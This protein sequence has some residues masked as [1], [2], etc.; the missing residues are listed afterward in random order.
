MAPR[1][2]QASVGDVWEL[3]ARQ[4]WVVSRAQLVEL[5]LSDEMIKH[6]IRTRRLH[7]LWRRVYAVGHPQPTQL[8]LWM[9]AVLACGRGTALSHDSAAEL[10]GIARSARGAMIHVTVPG[11]SGRRLRGIRTHRRLLAPA[12]VVE[13]RGIPVTT[14]VC[15]LIDYAAG[16]RSRSEVET[17][18]NEADRLDLVSPEALREALDANPGRRGVAKLR[19]ILDRLTFSLTDS[20]L[21]RRLLPIVDRAGLPRPKTQTV[22]N[23]F[24]VD[25]YWDVGLVVETDGLRYHRT[26]AQQGRDRLRD[27]VHTAAG[28]TTLR[29]THAQIRYEP[30]HVEA[31]LRSVYA[32]LA[33]SGGYGPSN[34]PLGRGAARSAGSSGPRRPRAA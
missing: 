25:F 17:A 16:K 31:M 4:H 8:G 27:Q 11:A 30:Q 18:V 12:A 7:P 3:A 15:T 14:P 5:G 29:F 32:R 10:W 19:T 34:A 20:E 21:E 23:G 9:A 22:L 26:P 28:L 33:T 6:R 13:H 2:R 24:R 1:K